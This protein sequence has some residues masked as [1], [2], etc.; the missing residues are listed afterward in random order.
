VG[1]RND[2]HPRK[3]IS[4]SGQRRA[5]N[6]ILTDSSSSMV[7][8]DYISPR[9]LPLRGCILRRPASASPVM[10]FKLTLLSNCESGE[11]SS[12]LGRIRVNARPPQAGGVACG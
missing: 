11:V 9:H 6:L 12:A 3:R 5:M 2:C 7:V 1:R 4:E 8:Q 10:V